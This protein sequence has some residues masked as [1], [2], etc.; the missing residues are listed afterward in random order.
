[1]SVDNKTAYQW[2]VE[3]AAETEVGKWTD[4]QKAELVN[5]MNEEYAAAVA[6]SGFVY[7]CFGHNDAGAEVLE[8]RSKNG[9]QQQFANVIVQG[10]LKNPITAFDYWLAH[11]ARRTYAGGVVF[12]PAGY[13]ETPKVKPGQLNLWRGFAIKPEAGDWSLYREHI[14]TVICGGN[15]AE[16]AWM[17]DWLAHSVQHPHKKPGS[18]LV[19]RSEE[20]GT[21][22]STLKK[23]M[24]KIFGRHSVSITNKEQVVG[25]FNAVLQEACFV[26]I[27]ES[28]FAGAKSEQSIMNNLITEDSI[29]IERKGIDPIQLDSCCGFLMLAN[30]SWVV[31]VSKDERRYGVYE[32]SFA[33][34]QAEKRPYWDA[35]YAQ[36]D[37]GGYEAM[38]HELLHREIKSNLYAP[39][40]TKGLMAQRTLSQDGIERFLHL[41]A[42]DGGIHIGEGDCFALSPTEKSTVRADDVRA[43]AKKHC[44]AYEGRALET[45]IGVWFRK[46]GV[47]RRDV[48]QVVNEFNPTRKQKYADV[49]HYTFPPLPEFVAKVEAALD[50]KIECAGIP[51]DGYKGFNDEDVPMRRT[52]G[53]GVEPDQGKR[54]KKRIANCRR[55]GDPGC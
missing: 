24:S 4:E 3:Q 51:V 32:F 31:P 37:N 43:A 36:L 13:G 33:M 9:L 6:G 15:D 50:V 35:I 55:K 17:M 7:V 5:R 16:F 2:A 47:T 40:K 25:R 52:D 20:K 11:P 39:P 8:F 41:L 14:R 46:L 44:D 30:R 42:S 21:G 38:F 34:T 53:G 12:K 49:A 22:K 28:F 26:A 19:L 45:H 29:V 1:M 18:A 54:P 23:C 10:T 27:E 48:R